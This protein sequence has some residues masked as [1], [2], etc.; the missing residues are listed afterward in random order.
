M[1]T[2]KRYCRICGKEIK[3]KRSNAVT[4]SRKCS[5]KNKDLSS[6]SSWRKKHP[7]TLQIARPYSIIPIMILII[8]I[9][10]L[11]LI[12]SSS[13]GTVKQGDCISL[14]QQCDTCTYV[15]L[16]SVKYPNST[17]D[18]LN[19]NMT[20]NDIDYNYSFCNTSI[21]GDYSYTVKGD[22]DGA[23]SS[24]TIY[25]TVTPTGSDFGTTQGITA[26][27]ILFGVLILAAI[28]LFIG[29][30]MFENDSLIP[31][32]FLFMVLSIILCIYSLHL[33]WVYSMNILQFGEI[34]STSEVIYIAF[35]WLI[36][37]VG[38]ISMILMAMSFLK[39]FGRMKQM[40][41]F[42]EGW[43]PITKAYDY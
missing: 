42:G 6:L 5:I 39:E 17:I 24:E 16:T 1:I 22:K 19:V 15:N 25:F 26:I 21:L 36:V 23:V 34:S 33:S 30:K 2:E 9:F 32:A 29:I 28:F 43:N 41:S 18:F 40:K 10:C 12:T 14:Y 7:S 27:G 4:C 37:A 31:I 13:L 35:L 11:S 3:S 20:K 38:I 8:G